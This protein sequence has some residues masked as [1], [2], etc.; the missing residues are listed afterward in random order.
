LIFKKKS[1]LF[2]VA[3]NKQANFNLF[4]G[5]FTCFSCANIS[6][7]VYSVFLFA[8]FYLC[9]V[10]TISQMRK[11]IG[12]WFMDIAKYV[13]SAVLISSFLGGLQ[14]KWLMYLMGFV[15]VIIAFGL[16]LLFINNRK[17]T[18]KK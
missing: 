11:E 10:K 17:K 6:L 18:T 1:T 7:F 16:G 8:F 13:A 2:D 5:G 3:G 15:T 4:S 14:Q 12:K 9:R